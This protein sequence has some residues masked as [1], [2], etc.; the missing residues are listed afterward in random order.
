M[1]IRVLKISLFSRNLSEN[2]KNSK[3]LFTKNDI[4]SACN[5]NSNSNKKIKYRYTE[6]EINEAW[7]KACL[8]TSNQNLETELNKIQK[9]SIIYKII[10][11]FYKK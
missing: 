5:T 2:C 11:F 1:K 6:D 9:P 3:E 10:N 4:V 7:R 8:I